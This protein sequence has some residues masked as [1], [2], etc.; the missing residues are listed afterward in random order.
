ML[1]FLA[2]YY[3][4][5]VEIILTENWNFKFIPSNWT[6]TV[7]WSRFKTSSKS[8]ISDSGTS[9]GYFG[10]GS[11]CPDPLQ[12]CMVWKHAFSIWTCHREI[13]GTYMERN[14]IERTLFVP[15][16]VHTLTWMSEETKF[17]ELPCYMLQSVCYYLVQFWSYL[18]L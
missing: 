12:N 15:L 8:L 17:Y 2:C 3:V 16:E 10:L 7:A 5:H 1:T 14:W 4:S 18:K 13:A 11:F 9:Q 6:A